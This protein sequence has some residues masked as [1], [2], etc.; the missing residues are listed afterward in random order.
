MGTHLYYL[1][2]E[3]REGKSFDGTYVFQSV[4]AAYRAAL[5]AF[6]ASEERYRTIAVMTGAGR[7]RRLVDVYNGVRW[8][9]E[10]EYGPV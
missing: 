7:Q 5:D 8:W 3:P 9:E 10:E 2:F 6:H 4:D 1:S